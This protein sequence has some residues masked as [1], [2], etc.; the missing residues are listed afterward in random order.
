MAEAWVRIVENLWGRL[1]GPMSFRFILQPLM[2]SIFAIVSGLQDA[3][4]GRRP[5]LWAIVTEPDHRLSLIKEGWARIGKVFLVAVALDL[6]YQIVVLDIR[7]G[8]AL[9]V[10]ILLAIAPYVLLRGVVTRVARILTGGG[11]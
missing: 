9:I 8:E 2:A 5:Y 4:L 7:P 11:R 1:D 10:A 3:R 6:V